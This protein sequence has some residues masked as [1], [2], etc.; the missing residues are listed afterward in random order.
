MTNDPL[1][2]KIRELL[3]RKNLTEAEKTEL[4]AWH[5]SQDSQTVVEA[6]IEQDLT[7]ALMNLKAA[8]VPSNFTSRVVNAIRTGEAREG[9]PARPI[10]WL[11]GRL[12]WLVRAM[13]VVVLSAGFLGYQHVQAAR[14]REFARSVSTVS[15]FA[16]VPS[17]EILQDFEAIRML[18]QSPP[19]DEQLLSLLESK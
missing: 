2:Q 5:A 9:R 4:A 14:Q 19:A 3:W 17:P 8:P 12:R 13:A 16:T 10:A 6:E 1:P 7:T 18:N 15:D 11:P